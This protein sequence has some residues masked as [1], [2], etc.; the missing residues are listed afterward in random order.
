M[1]EFWIIMNL[2]LSFGKS[3]YNYGLISFLLG[4][5]LALLFFVPSMIYNEG[6]FLFYGDFNAQQVP[7]YQMMHDSILNGDTMWSNTTDLGANVIGSYS[8]YLMGSPFFWITMLFPSSF[9]PYLMAPLLILKFAFASLFAYIYLKRYVSHKGFA[10]L[11]GLLYAFSGFSLYNVFFN[12]FHEAI[13]I[14]PLLLYAIDEYMYNK[15]KGIVALAV[16]SAC[17]LNYYFFVGQV[18]FVI[19]YWVIRVT[20]KTYPKIKFKELSLLAFEVIIGFLMTF[21]I[22][23][24]S[25]LSVIQNNRLDTWPEGWNAVLYD[26]NQRYV[27]IIESFFFPP[28]VAARPNFTPESKSEWASIAA[29]LPLVGMT[30]VIGFLQT[31]GKHWLKKLIPLL[32]VVALVPIFNALFQGLNMNYYARWFYMIELVMVLATLI[33]LE[34]AK[35]DWLKATRLSAGITAVILVLIGFM[36]YKEYSKD[37]GESKQSFGLENYPERFWIYGAISLVGICVFAFIIKAFMHNR[38]KF[39]KA[40]SIAL[41]LVIIVYGNFIIYIG[42]LQGGSSREFIQDYALNKGENLNIDDIKEVRSDF[43]SCVD[44]LGMYWQIPNIQAFHSIVPGSIM[45]FYP[46]F[47]EARDVASRPTTEIYPIRSLLSVKYLFDDPT[48]DEEFFTDNEPKMPGWEYYNTGNG[49]NIYEN[50]YYI[51]MGFMYDSFICKEEYDKIPTEYKDDALL[52]AMVL[53]QKQIKKYSYITNYIEGEFDL[54]NNKD[55]EDEYSGISSEFVYTTDAYYEDCKSR[56]NN[57][58][59][60]FK[61]VNNGFTAT[62]DNQGEDNLLFFSVPYEDGWSA[63]VDGEEVDIEKVNISFMA[64]KV[65][66][67]HKSEVTFRYK[68]PG[69]AVGTAV[70]FVSLVFF[71][72]YLVICY[73]IKNRN[74]NI[75]IR[76][77]KRQEEV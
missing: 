2:R 28:D 31:R 46:T 55:T 69:L 3:K 45:D 15:R 38:K 57:C 1:G 25:I 14:F 75:K 58:C 32:F 22:L 41:S 52:K 11:G 10:V 60:D 47:E 77:K 56:K 7:F 4:I 35:V 65:K 12:H 54:L 18:V 34:N 63:Y 72:A 68:T 26:V 67:H 29:W 42:I 16:F 17:V 76:K 27:H 19:I 21:V 50:K 43:Y 5:G 64:V 74:K 44:N 23:L 39:I 30:G 37:G 24:P 48:D 71:V 73:I 61:Y 33:A 70:T 9:V 6:L 20:T 13:L 8:F 53:S 49:V 36:P 51:P 40:M 62:I 59:S 66:G